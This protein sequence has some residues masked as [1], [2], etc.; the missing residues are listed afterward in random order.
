MTFQ[1]F[2]PEQAA[3]AQKEL[4]Q[5]NRKGLYIYY[6]IN[7][8]RYYKGSSTQL[9]IVK[10]DARFTIYKD[11]NIHFFTFTTNKLDCVNYQF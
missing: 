11:P 3:K 2:T 4:L 1:A 7:G 9:E 8:Q 6:T 5:K 10:A